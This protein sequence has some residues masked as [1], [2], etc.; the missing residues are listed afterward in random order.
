M[1]VKKKKLRIQM[2]GTE[3]WVETE[4]LN[5]AQTKLVETILKE[6]L[7]LKVKGQGYSPISQPVV[8]EDRYLKKIGK[9]FMPVPN[10]TDSKITVFRTT[11]KAIKGKLP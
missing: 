6:N 3:D 5:N 8:I 7:L 9:N 11:L 10:K 2:F 4:F 1:G